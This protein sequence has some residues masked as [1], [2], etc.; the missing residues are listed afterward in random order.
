MILRILSLSAMVWAISIFH[1]QAQTANDALR[2]SYYQVGGTARTIGVGGALGALGADFS[3]LSTNPAG[4]G[5]YRRSEF[6]V[7]P[8][9]FMSNVD[10]YLDS[11]PEGLVESESK[12]NF[13]LNNIGVVLF[14]Q[15]RNFK[16]KTSNFGIGLNRVANFN[17]RFF[18]EGDSPGSLVL[19]FQEQANREGQLDDFTSGVAADAFAIYIDENFDP[20]LYLSDFDLAPGAL[21]RRE[22][23]VATSG[24]INELV[25]SFAGNYDERIIIGATL[26]V[27]FLSFTE[28]KTYRESDPGTGAN[29]NV[30]FFDN[31]EY[32]ER[33]TTTGAG[34]NLKLGLILRVNQMV[35]LGAAFHTP[36]AF[37]LEDNFSSS[38]VYR[39]TENNQPYAYDGQSP[40]GLFN[41]RLR[42]PWR[43]IGSAG[44]I[45]GKSGFVSGEVEYTDYTS[46]SF[47]YD[48]FSGSETEVNSEIDRT[49]SKA[50]NIRV[51]GEY[52]F[53]DFR[54]RAG[55]GL[56]QSPLEGDDTINN[57]L[58]LGAG[59]R[60]E[61]FF[62]DLAFRNFNA[63]ETYVP[64]QATLSPM[65]FVNNNISTNQVFLTLGFKF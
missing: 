10:S 43:A 9:F 39:Y 22:Q 19:A 24:S 8:S 35:R 49:L 6:T 53:Q 63:K 50:L 30:P 5:M 3:T 44:F 32:R 41:Y 58:S 51:G 12:N 62:L 18:Y 20:N 17:Q 59:Y 21:V 48:G 7:T 40:D 47:R 61:S 37:R 64:Y 27:P 65:Q 45:F 55:V 14:S 15:P 11:D 60:G 36:T 34:I 4:L 29:G 26:G 38:M 57:S 56:H 54:F 31:L 42:T 16:W 46:S 33:L 52:A 13:N 28:D 25:F 23:L 2:Y 1:L